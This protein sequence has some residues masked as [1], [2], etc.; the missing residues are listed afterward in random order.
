[1][2]TFADLGSYGRLGNQL[3]QY[4]ALRAIGLEKGYEVKI[5]PP[6]N[7][8]WHGQDCL[9]DNF[10]LECGF[11]EPADYESI[12]YL[13]VELDVNK[14]D[15]R[16]YD[17]PDYTNLVGFFQSTLYFKK[18]ESQI[19]KE[20]RLKEEISQ[21]CKE[22]I[23]KL[24]KDHK[25]EIVSLHMRR[26]DQTDGTN[27][28]SVNFYGANNTFEKNSLYGTYFEKAKGLFKNKKVKFLI[29]SGGAR[30]EDFNAGDMDWCKQNFKD[31]VFLY[32]EGNSTIKDFG[33]IKEC[34]HNI[35]CH[36]TS[37]GWWGAFLNE[38]PHKIVTAPKYY[39]V[40]DQT[41]EREEFYPPDW[42]IIP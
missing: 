17:V 14:Y 5:P 18:H 41:T 10:S 38:N 9:L 27:P 28:D 4:A 22:I 13:Y 21:E 8:S 26:G 39:F 25:C 32:S 2:I 30:T 29:F 23:S 24:K 36:S 19:R 11:L 34:D 31:E 6:S 7:S 16:V 40:D 15:G 37:F 20:F 3:F 35:S 42:K 1:M 33:L 12:K